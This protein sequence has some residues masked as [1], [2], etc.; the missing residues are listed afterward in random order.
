MSSNPTVQSIALQAIG[1][2]HPALQNKAKELFNDVG[3]M[4]QFVKTS[5]S[6]F[7]QTQW[8]A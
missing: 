1:G 2:L 8:L 3:L 6:T 4:E 7:P 5:L